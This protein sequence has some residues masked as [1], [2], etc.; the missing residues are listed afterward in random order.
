MRQVTANISE[1]VD[2][3]NLEKLMDLYYRFCDLTTR[4]EMD[5]EIITM[6]Q[7]LFDAIFGLSG[8]TP[9]QLCKWVAQ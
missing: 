9:G 7:R 1:M 3:A 8:C 5:D 4:G 2:N 6:Q